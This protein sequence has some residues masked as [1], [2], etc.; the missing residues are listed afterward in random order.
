[1]Y[2]NFKLIDGSMEFTAEEIKFAKDLQSTFVEGSVDNDIRWNVA[3]TEGT[4]E[5]TFEQPLVAQVLQ[6]SDN[7][8]PMGGSTEVADVSH[9]TPTVQFNAVCWP[10]GT[11]AHSWQTVAS[12]GSSIGMKGMM[13]SA[14][15]QALTAYDLLTKP[16]VLAEAQ[17]EFK[18]AKNG[19]P[20]VTP[21]PEDAYPH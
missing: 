10:I 8:P 18:A 5:A 19:Q 11:P 4:T 21:L 12:C 20:Y 16:D 9:I 6:H 13:F 14:K 15:A 17:E 7:P 3:Q 1:M 2:E